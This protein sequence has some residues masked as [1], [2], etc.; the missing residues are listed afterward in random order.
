MQLTIPLKYQPALIQ[1]LSQLSVISVYEMFPAMAPLANTTE[2]HRLQEKFTP[3]EAGLGWSASTQAG[4]QLGA[5]GVTLAMAIST[6]AI[7]G[8]VL[9]FSNALNFNTFIS[10]IQ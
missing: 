1:T 9:M 8:M 5:L 4:Y 7:T 2:L 6:G 10:F 3:I